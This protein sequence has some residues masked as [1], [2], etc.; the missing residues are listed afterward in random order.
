MPRLGRLGLKSGNERLMV[1]NLFLP[2]ADF[3]LHSFSMFGLL[4]QE[5]VVV[6]FVEFHPLI[7]H[8]D[9]VGRCAIQK[10]MIV[11]DHHTAALEALQKCLEPLNRQNVQMVGGLIQNKMSGRAANT[12][13]N[14]TRNLKP[15]DSVLNS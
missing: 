2:F 9:D 7:I 6:A 12:W 15:P 11:A 3:R 1:G 5:A 8:I 13:P 4:P 14:N 10:P